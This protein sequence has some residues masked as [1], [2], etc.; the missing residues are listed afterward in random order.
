M[1]TS[2]DKLHFGGGIGSPLDDDA[3]YRKQVILV[4]KQSKLVNRFLP[5]GGDCFIHFDGGNI[6]RKGLAA[7]DFIKR[8]RGTVVV[9]KTKLQSD[10]PKAHGPLGPEFGPAQVESLAG[11]IGV[12]EEPSGHD[13]PVHDAGIERPNLR[14]GEHAAESRDGAKG[15]KS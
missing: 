12:V 8:N 15:G 4:A 10:L 5:V 14:V 2:L 3:D 6:R 7:D 11:G 9:F 13:H 1:K